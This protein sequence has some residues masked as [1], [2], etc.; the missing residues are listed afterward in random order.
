M[1]IWLIPANILHITI[2]DISYLAW[3]A[4]RNSFGLF[5]YRKTVKS[6]RADFP[7]IAYHWGV[8]E[9]T[10]WREVRIIMHSNLSNSEQLF[11]GA[12]SSSKQ[13]RGRG[14]DSGKKGVCQVFPTANA[15]EKKKSAL[16]QGGLWDKNICTPFYR[17]HPLSPTSCEGSFVLDMVLKVLNKTK[18][19]SDMKY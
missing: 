16:P 9:H 14:P 6:S 5:D 19:L 18:L 10:V 1:I 12:G 17:P 3:L 8:R 15:I 13:M 7:L 4:G 11:Q 2:A